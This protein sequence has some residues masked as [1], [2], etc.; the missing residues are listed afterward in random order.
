MLPFHLNPL[1]SA[2]ALALG[3]EDT[4]TYDSLWVDRLTDHSKFSLRPKH[5]APSPSL[6]LTSHKP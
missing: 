1:P 4:I 3:E 2:S 6:P 5:L